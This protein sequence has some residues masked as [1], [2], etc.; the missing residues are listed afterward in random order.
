MSARLFVMI[1]VGALVLAACDKKKDEGASPA[2]SAS[3]ASAASTSATV[4]ANATTGAKAS[5]P[6]AD[7]DIPVKADF[8]GEVRKQITKANYKSELDKAE[9]EIGK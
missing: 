9:K 3:V 1:S 2:T 5:A 4:A 8:A 7:K 6:L